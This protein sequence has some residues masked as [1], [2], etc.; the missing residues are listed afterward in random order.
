MGQMGW[1]ELT[2][3]E[4][5]GKRGLEIMLLDFSLT[6]A[7]QHGKTLT[8]HIEKINT[9]CEELRSYG[10]YAETTCVQ[11]SCC[12]DV[13]IEKGDTVFCNGRVKVKPEFINALSRFTQKAHVQYTLD[14]LMPRLTLIGANV[15]INRRQ[16]TFVCYVNVVFDA[17]KSV[18]Y[19][20]TYEDMLKLRSDVDVAE[21]HH[22]IGA[23]WPKIQKAAWKRINVDGCYA[24]VK[25]N[26]NGCISIQY[27]DT[28]KAREA[29]RMLEE[30][31]VGNG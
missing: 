5:M 12:L 15:A 9:F 26:T 29:L 23:A 6:V 8:N 3:L 13:K 17:C 1:Q 25:P 22:L 14:E 4:F 20:P 30:D 24:F 28:E 2:L 19:D 27:G 10:Y 31:L 21:V 7:N 18:N 16:N 11:N